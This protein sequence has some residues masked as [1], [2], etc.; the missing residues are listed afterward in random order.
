MPNTKYHIPSEVYALI[1]VS[2]AIIGGIALF[3][4]LV[5]S[6]SNN[7]ID[8]HPVTNNYWTEVPAP[9][10]GYVCFVQ[11]GDRQT[12]TCFPDSVSLKNPAPKAN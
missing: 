3:S 12:T 8:N 4:M 6:L 5:E 11:Y 1:G 9:V 10:N 7:I 2:V